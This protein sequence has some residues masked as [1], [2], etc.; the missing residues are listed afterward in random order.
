MCPVLGPGRGAGR[1]TGRPPIPIKKGDVFGKLTVL[2]DRVGAETFVLVQCSCGSPPKLVR[3]GALTSRK[4]PTR[5]CGCEIRVGGVARH[6]HARVGHRTATYR[7]WRNMLR[8][9]EVCPRWRRKRT[10]FSAFL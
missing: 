5:S 3:A 9:R 7:S 1:V 8:S 2:A 10:G 6:G 4:R